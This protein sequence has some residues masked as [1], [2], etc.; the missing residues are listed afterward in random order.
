MRICIHDICIHIRLYIYVYIDVQI[1]QCIHNMNMFTCIIY[2]YMDVYKY[3]Y[4][5]LICL[6]VYA[7]MNLCIY[8][9]SRYL[10]VGQAVY[11]SSEESLCNDGAQNS[12][13][14]SQA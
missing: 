10:R 2:I 1:Y 14:E 8:H 7:F 5:L 6:S 11:S 3:T 9:L 4:T 13:A 12:A